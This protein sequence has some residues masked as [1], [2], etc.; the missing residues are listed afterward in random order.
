M[1]SMRDVTVNP[2]PMLMADA[3]TAVAARPCKK[4][5]EREKFALCSDH[6]G[7]ILRRQSGAMTI[8]HSP[9][10]NMNVD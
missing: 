1:L 3:N 7:S 10:G 5:K 4:R 6:N 8:G 9:K 2:P